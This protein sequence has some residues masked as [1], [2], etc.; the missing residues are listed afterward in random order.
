MGPASEAAP[1]VMQRGMLGIRGLRAFARSGHFV[2]SPGQTIL[3]CRR[4]MRQDAASSTPGRRCLAEPAPEGPV[5]AVDGREAQAGRDL[6]ERDPTLCQQSLRD[7]AL[8][9][10]D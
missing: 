4:A 7:Q 8:A 10:L 1:A 6:L 2:A 9:F 3:G 5:K